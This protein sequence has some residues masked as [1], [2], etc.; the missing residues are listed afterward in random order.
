MVQCELNGLILREPWISPIVS[1][2]SAG[3]RSMSPLSGCKKQLPCYYPVY[4]S[5]VGCSLGS[6][7]R[8]YTVIATAWGGPADYLDQSCGILVDPVS[9]HALVVGFAEAMQRLSTDGLR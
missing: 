7:G 1:F 9:E 8:R 2:S 4:L 3:Y 6:N 5:A